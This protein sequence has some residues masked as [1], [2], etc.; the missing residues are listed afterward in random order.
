M[1]FDKQ[2][3][4]LSALAHPGRLAV[5]R[6]VARHAPASMRPG[7][8]VEALG[9]KPNT[10]SVYLGSLTD[11]GLL[12][13]QRHG[14]A[15]HYRAALPAIGSLVDFLVADCC[16]GRPD[17]CAPLTTEAMQSRSLSVPYNVLFI[18]TGNSARSIF[19]EALLRDHG[20]AKFNVHSAGTS[21]HAGINPVAAEVLRRNGH[22]TSQL[23]PQTLADFRG[24]H[25][26]RLDFVFTVCDRAAN[27][28]C[29]PWTGQPIT[30]HWG[31]PDPALASGTNAEV[32]N[33]FTE[34]Y[35]QL[36]RRVAAF[37]ALPFDH[38]DSVSLQKHIDDIG[39]SEKP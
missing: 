25:A 35:G 20:G 14:T 32:L 9:L 1:E 29:P 5:F 22:D 7:E 6:L 27:E 38:L 31:M 21:A 24:P 28:D 37:A 18:C 30:S 15:I 13:A 4:R 34:T 2:T 23:R 12:E 11:A 3:R 17:L 39:I 16:R 19:A 26:P 8:I 33:A 10:L 36:Q